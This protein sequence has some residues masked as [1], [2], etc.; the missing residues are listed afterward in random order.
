[1]IFIVLDGKDYGAPTRRRRQWIYITPVEYEIDQLSPDWQQPPW[2][3]AFEARLKN[4][5]T[6]PGCLD[7]FLFHESDP[8]LIE[9]KR[10]GQRVGEP[11]P[12]NND[13]ESATKVKDG[14]KQDHFTA[15]TEACLTWPPDVSKLKE[16]IPS[17]S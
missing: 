13:G 1:M 6:G 10:H 7:D 15:F 8:V 3:L 14:W 11:Q 16:R 2:V 9:W 4:M 5:Q 12:G 17:L